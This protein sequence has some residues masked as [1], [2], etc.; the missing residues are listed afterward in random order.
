[1]PV[2]DSGPAL[3][4]RPV[5]EVVSKFI[6]DSKIFL[7][8]LLEKKSLKAPLN[9]LN[10]LFD[11]VVD[12]PTDRLKRVLQKETEGNAFLEKIGKELQSELEQ[13]RVTGDRAQLLDEIA[14][15]A[16]TY[17]AALWATCS[18]EERLL[19][20]QL[21]RHRLMN[22]NDRQNVRR[23]IARGL[24]VRRPNLETMNESFRLFVLGVSEPELEKFERDMSSA[25]TWM[26]VRVPATII[27]FGVIVFFFASQKDLLNTTSALL[28]G[29]AA[30]LPALAKLVGMIGARRSAS[31]GSS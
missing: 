23:L 21:A 7:R 18:R 12:S 29:L 26:R 11:T 13:R 2:D 9:R 22:G 5:R 6:H 28:T 30:G 20:S 3:P 14:E 1:M 19:L 15:R 16:S 8:Y 10:D 4:R 17:Y 25:S 31:Q 24:V 27:L